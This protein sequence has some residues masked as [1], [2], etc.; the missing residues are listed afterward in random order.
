MDQILL[1]PGIGQELYLATGIVDFPLLLISTEEDVLFNF[2]IRSDNTQ[3]LLNPELLPN[4]HG[5]VP[6]TPQSQYSTS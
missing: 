2:T 3:V 5:T 6:V 1:L 4:A